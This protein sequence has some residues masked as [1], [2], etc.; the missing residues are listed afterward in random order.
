M[1][2]QDTQVKTMSLSLVRVRL[3]KCLNQVCFGGERIVVTS[4]G[5]PKAAIIPIEDLRRLQE[6]EQAR[7]GQAQQEP[8]S[9]SS[10]KETEP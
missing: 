4:H 10:G 8:V 2:E 3:S 1:P 5:E 7:A 9:D 6:D